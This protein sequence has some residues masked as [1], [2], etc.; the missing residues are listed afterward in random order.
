[1]LKRIRSYLKFLRSMVRVNSGLIV[2]MWKLTRLPQPVITVFGGTRLS[3]DHPASDIICELARQLAHSGFSILTGGG[4]GIMEAANQGA[5]MHSE[6]HSKS[7]IS[8]GIG[9]SKLKQKFNKYIQG[10]IVQ[11]YFFTRK[12]LL[13]R[14]S[15][16]FVVGPGG[17]GTLDELTEVLTLV[18]THT[19]SK[20][21]IV[22]IGK[23]YWQP[24]VDWIHN[25]PLKEGLITKEDAELIQIANS[26]EEAHEIIISS[27]SGYIKCGIEA[28]SK[29]KN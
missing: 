6:K 29:E 19:M 2:G 20:T 13:V 1:M 24:F 5:T 26:A 22:L 23:D 8:M 17:F 3:K 10:H 14:Y 28:E 15:V 21:P 11:P 7:M 9:M 18:Q 12:W 25:C 4:P 27:C 16:G